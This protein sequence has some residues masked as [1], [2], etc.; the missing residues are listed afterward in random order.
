[1]SCRSDVY[2]FLFNVKYIFRKESKVRFHASSTMNPVPRANMTKT[3]H[4]ATLKKLPADWVIYEEMTRANRLGQAKMC[5]LVSPITVAMLAGPARLAQEA[6]RD[7]E[8]GIIMYRDTSFI[9][10][11]VSKLLYL[12]LKMIMSYLV[13][14]KCIKIITRR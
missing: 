7:V 11:A 14:F 9:L 3:T 13:M 5:T 10:L 8:N 4:S 2:F 6:I 12:S 1:M